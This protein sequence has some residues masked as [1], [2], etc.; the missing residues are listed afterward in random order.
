MSQDD[1]VANKSEMTAVTRNLAFRTASIHRGHGSL[2]ILLYLVPVVPGPGGSRARDLTPSFRAPTTAALLFDSGFDA[3]AG[4]FT[5]VLQPGYMLRY[6]VAIGTSVYD[7]APSRTT[8]SI[9][10]EWECA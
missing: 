3:N 5:Y 9:T 10:V 2:A 8:T 1:T 6:D 7:G 4:L